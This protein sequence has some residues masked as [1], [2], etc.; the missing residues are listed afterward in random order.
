MIF[1]LANAFLFR[2]PPID[3]NRNVFVYDTDARHQVNEMELSGRVRHRA[4]PDGRSETV[5]STTKRRRT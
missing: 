1:N 2:S 5:A 4:R 3:A